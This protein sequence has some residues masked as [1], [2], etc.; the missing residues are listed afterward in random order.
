MHGDAHLGN[1]LAGGRW[2]DLDEACFGPSE[3]DLVF[4]R[5][6]SLFFGERTRETCDALEAYGSHGEQAVG[7]LAVDRAPSTANPSATS[8]CQPP[9][10]EPASSY[11]PTANHRATSPS[12][13]CHGAC[14]ATLVEG[15]FKASAISRRRGRIQLGRSECEKAVCEDV[16]RCGPSLCTSASGYL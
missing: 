11:S 1:A 14:N 7:V 4:V 13:H 2:L 6:C 16:L 5:H 12:F 9:C 8:R 10:N 15:G 3:W